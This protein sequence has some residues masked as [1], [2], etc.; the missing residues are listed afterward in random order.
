MVW[1][2]GRE[3]YGRRAAL[4]GA[5]LYAAN[6]VVLVSAVR[7]DQEVIMTALGM[8]GLTLLVTRRSHAMAGLAGICLGAAFWIKYPMLVFLP[9]YLVAARRRAAAVVAG[10]GGAVAVLFLPYMG[11]ARRLFS[12]TVT[13]QTLQRNHTPF[14]TRVATTGVF[15]LAVNPFAVAALRTIRRPLWLALGFATGCVFLFT[16]TAYSHYFVPVAPFAALLGGPIAARLA[17][18]SLRTAL[19]VCLAV[20]TSWAISI[21]VVS[22][23]FVTIPRFSDIQPVVRDLQRSTPPGTPVLANRFELAYLAHRPWVAHYFWDDRGTLSATSLARHLPHDAVTA[24]YPYNNAAAY[25]AGF[26]NYLDEHYP[27]RRLDGIML[28][29][30]GQGRLVS[31]RLR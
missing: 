11:E 24:L 14:T 29:Q 1:R 4:A 5:I 20:A 6:P 21:N 3:L 28:W 7:V 17:R 15:W 23:S 9:V 31:E 27:R 2:I 26:E 13:W 10:F 19:A 16:A 18:I 30:M 12:E 25:P 22:G 8:A